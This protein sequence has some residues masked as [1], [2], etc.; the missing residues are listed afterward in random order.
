MFERLYSIIEGIYRRVTPNYA[1]A[2]LTFNTKTKELED[3]VYCMSGRARFH[4][5]DESDQ[6]RRQEEEQT[7]RVAHSRDQRDK[8]PSS[9]LGKDGKPHH[10]N[11]YK[12]QRD[13]NEGSN[14][15]KGC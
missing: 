12:P 7:P 4:K 11:R 1:F 9:I 5:E 15:T 3:L 8:V 2:R 10:I 6:H 13:S 14:L